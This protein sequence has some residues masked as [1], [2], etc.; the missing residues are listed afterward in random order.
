MGF[1]IFLKKPLTLIIIVSVVV[2]ATLWFLAQWVFPQ[3]ESAILHYSTNVGIDFIGQSSQIITLPLV[4]LLIFVGNMFLGL[5]LKKMDPKTAW[6]LWGI[7]PVSQF[8]LTGA[9]SLVWLANQ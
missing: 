8:I 9:F 1:I 2:N 5:I 4:G 3:Q 7:I 6:I